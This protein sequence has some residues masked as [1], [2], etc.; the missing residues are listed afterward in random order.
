MHPLL[1]RKACIGMKIVSYL[2]NDAINPPVTAARKE[3]VYVVNP[4]PDSVEAIKRKYPTVFAE[5]VGCLEGKYHIKID[6]NIDPVQHTPLRVPIAMR[7]QLK[8]S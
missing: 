7:E 3:T 2:D 5:G 8:S 4:D 1:G 6:P